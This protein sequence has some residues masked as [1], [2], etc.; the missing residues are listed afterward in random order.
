MKGF[1]NLKEQSNEVRI[2]SLEIARITGKMHKDLLR[3]IRRMETAWEKINGRKFTLVDYTDEKGEKRPMYLFTKKEFLYVISKYKDEVR[4][5]L[6]IRWEEL[7]TERLKG[8][9]KPVAEQ[10]KEQPVDRLGL[11]EFLE[12]QAD[13]GNFN[14]LYSQ[15]I[16]TES[17]NVAAGRELLPMPE[18]PKQEESYT[19]KQVGKKVAEAL[20][21]EEPVSSNMIGKIATIF[22]LKTEDN[23]IT[24]ETFAHNGK[25]VPAFY[26]YK[27]S[28]GKVI[29]AAEKY[30]EQNPNSKLAKM[31]LAADVER[32]LTEDI[33]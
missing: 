10:P 2:S 14:P 18:T 1:E 21:L 17:V 33:H 4:A 30:I 27:S 26:Y 20:G 6:V 16:R 9:S 23:G 13:S 12:R 22:G 28:I 24:R 7:E 29:E 15:M 11:A 5:K 25:Q 19:P 8:E 31:K 3:S 32:S